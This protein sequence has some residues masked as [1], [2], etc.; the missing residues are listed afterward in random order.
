MEIIS[1]VAGLFAYHLIMLFSLRFCN[2]RNY[3]VI[4]SGVYGAFNGLVFVIVLYVYGYIAYGL[5]TFEGERGLYAL[6]AA[7]G[8]ILFAALRCAQGRRKYEKAKE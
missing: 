3:S 2:S 6:G 4:H 7:I 1:V 8:I 5:R